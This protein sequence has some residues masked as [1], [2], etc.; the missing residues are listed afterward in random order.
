[1]ARIFSFIK[2]NLAVPH[3]FEYIVRKYSTS[4]KIRGK[5][6]CPSKRRI[7]TNFT[8]EM[9]LC[10]INQIYEVFLSSIKDTPRGKEPSNETPVLTESMNMDTWVVGTSNQLFKTGSYNETKFQKKKRSSY[11]QNSVLCNRF[12]LYSPFYLS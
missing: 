6:T 5:Y 7:L 9:V 4:L 2:Q 10:F 1:M 8:L 11:W 3:S 12:I